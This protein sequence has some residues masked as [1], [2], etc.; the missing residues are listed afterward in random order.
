[1]GSH[2]FIKK[3]RN[4]IDAETYPLYGSGSHFAA[5]TCVDNG[6][7]EFLKLLQFLQRELKDRNPDFN[8]PFRIHTDRL[9][10]NGVEYKAVMMLNVESR[11]TRAMSMMLIDLKVAIAQC[12]SLRSP[13]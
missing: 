9:I 11:W 1:M 6:I 7:K 4:G 12:I 2:S 3:T 5:N 10:D 8:A 13:A